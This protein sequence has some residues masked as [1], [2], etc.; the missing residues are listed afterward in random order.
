[1]ACC[2]RKK[3]LCSLFIILYSLFL[4]NPV[5]A[6][7]AADLTP[8]AC[9]FS[10]TGGPFTIGTTVSITASSTNQDSSSGRLYDWTNTQVGSDFAPPISIQYSWDTTGLTAGSN[11]TF[12][13]TVVDTSGNSNSCSATYTLG[14]T[15]RPWLKTTVGDVHSNANINVSGGPP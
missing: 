7:W 10:P 5:Y 11:Y 12:S 6:D 8:P 9:S 14:T 4:T 2:T 13:N 3:V 15:I 1:M